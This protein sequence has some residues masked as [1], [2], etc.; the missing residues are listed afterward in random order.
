[1][2]TSQTEIRHVCL[3]VILEFCLFRAPSQ[4]SLLKYHILFKIRKKNPTLFWEQVGNTAL[5]VKKMSGIC[6]WF[7]SF[8]TKFHRLYFFVNFHTSL[9]ST[10]H[11]RRVLYLHQ[12]F[13]GCMSNYY[14]QF[15][16]SICQKRLHVTELLSDW[17]PI[18][19]AV[20][21]GQKIGSRS[22]T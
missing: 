18:C 17:H 2:S 20:R 21:S 5:Y 22:G 1:M 10:I 9:T 4:E 3:S 7:H 8:S 14:P 13:S 15:G 11:A 6:V 16:M 19:Y 12:T